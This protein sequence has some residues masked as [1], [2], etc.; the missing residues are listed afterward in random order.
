[1]LE[2]NSSYENNNALIGGAIEVLQTYFV[3]TGSLLMSYN[4]AEYGGAIFIAYADVFFHGATVSTGTLCGACATNYSLM[5]G[6]SQCQACSNKY[7]SILAA[8]TAA[9]IALVS[10]LTVLQLTVAS[11]M[12]N[13]II[14]YTNIVQANKTLFLPVNGQNVL[15]LFIAWLN[16]D[17]GFKT[18]FYDGMDAYAQ[19]WLQFAFPAYVWILIC[20]IITS[21]YSITVSKLIGSNP[22]AVLA[23]LLLM[24]YAKILRII[25]EVYSFV[26]LD[27]PDNQT[28]TVWLKDRCKCAL[29]APHSDNHN[30]N[31]PCHLLP[32]LHSTTSNRIQALPLLWQ[33]VPCL[34]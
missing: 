1:M 30:F 27:Y 14:L 11:G 2:G 34:D 12:I 23:T 31:N 22:I 26:D 21:R 4:Q 19:T 16:L 20:L 13:S 25:I 9:G 29:L 7:L 15:T 6:T 32:P 10:L 24:S 17:L 5:L 33:E 18:C 28:A 8:F 3:I